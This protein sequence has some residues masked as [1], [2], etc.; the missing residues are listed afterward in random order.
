M[1]TTAPSTMSDKDKAKVDCF[2]LSFNNFKHTTELIVTG[3]P[4]S[5]PS[6]DD[7]HQNCSTQVPTQG[8]ESNPYGFAAGT[9][10]TQEEI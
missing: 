5:S 4:S 3:F 10:M 6:K 1:K 2:H 8:S 7:Q 9:C